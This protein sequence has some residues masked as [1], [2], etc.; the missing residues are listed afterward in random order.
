MA[1]LSSEIHET[2]SQLSAEGDAL[3]ERGGYEAAIEKYNAAWALVP[4]PKSNW[5]ASTWLMEAIGDAAFLGGYLTSAQEALEYA[6]HCPDGFGNP[7]IHLRLGQVLY[8][9]GELDRAG[10][11][12]TRAYM[13][14]GDEIFAAEEPKYRTFLAM[15]AKLK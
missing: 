4:E 7:F 3:A 2:I 15:R 9:K 11:E 8:D 13:A 12:L 5:N 14:A 1:E 6:M 10:D